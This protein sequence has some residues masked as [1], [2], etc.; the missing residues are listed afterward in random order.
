M[1]TGK[2]ADAVPAVVD[3]RG[4]RS[5][6]RPGVAAALVALSFFLIVGGGFAALMT[7]GVFGSGEDTGQGSAAPTGSGRTEPG[8]G[9][10]QQPPVEE[11]PAQ[12]EDPDPAEPDAIAALDDVA[13]EAELTRRA[14]D[15][16]LEVSALDGGWVPQ[17][18]S[19]CAGLAVDIEPGWTPDGHAETSSVTLAQIAAFHA[20]LSRRFDALTTR[21]TTIG[22]DA[23]TGTARS[24]CAGQ[25]VWMSLVPKRFTDPGA[26]NAW[27]DRNVPPVDECQARLVAPGARSRTVART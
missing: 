23:D 3:P 7:L 24:R 5:A 21:P 26:A 9:A 13:A 18:S 6:M 2:P 1:G 25:M 10:T 8:S 20:A 11:L 22:I 12:T 4:H 16:A 19:K 27:C 15:D 17:V 14:D